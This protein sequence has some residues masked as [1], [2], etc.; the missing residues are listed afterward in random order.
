MTH[1]GFAHL[2]GLLA[3]VVFGLWAGKTPIGSRL[4]APVIIIIAG[5]ALSNLGIMPRTAP[6]YDTILANAVPLAVPL[7]LMSAN[8][9]RI[10]TEMGTMLVA[11]LFGAAGSVLGSIIAFYMIP[12]PLHGDVILGSAIG[13]YVGGT[14]NFLSVIQAMGAA[15]ETYLVSSMIV[16]FTIAC[17]IY[18]II[19]GLLPSSPWLVA[20]LGDH[21]D[22]ATAV[23][24]AGSSDQTEAPAPPPLDLIRVFSLLVYSSAVCVVGYLAKSMIGIDM[25]P[26]VIITALSILLANIAPGVLTRMTGGMEIGMAILYMFFAA[27]AATT[28]VTQISSLTAWLVVYSGIVA[29]VHIAFL[30]LSR[31]FVKASLAELIIASAAAYTGPAN[32]AGLATARGW[33]SLIAPGIV[34]GLLGYAIATF[35][36]LG[37]VALVG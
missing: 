2:F 22:V 14:I 33:P 36:A 10:V 9:K 23:A 3:I 13:S 8:F 28:D 16:G 17:T 34:C 11:F 6:V 29:V 12:F 21:K 18:F 32:A 4:S 7:F 25:D 15:Q 20:R 37:V 30:L 27:A 26:I 31:Y 24:D 1:I 5:I 19:M 35:V